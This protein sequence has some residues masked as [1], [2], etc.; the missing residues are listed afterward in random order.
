MQTQN[1]TF[2]QLPGA[3]TILLKE[4]SQLK[5]MLTDLTTG[6]P[7]PKTANNDPDLITIKEACKL[8]QVSRP[9][10]WKYE[11]QGKVNV[12]GIGGRRLLK[13]SEL[14]DGLTLKK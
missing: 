3:V 9:T 10:L 1:L 14:I 2:D 11:K 4:V 6:E 5:Q 13:R 12:Y 7:Q 8:L